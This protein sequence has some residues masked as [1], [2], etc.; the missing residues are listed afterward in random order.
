MP[1]RL[2][3]HAPVL[4]NTI[5]HCAGAIAFGILLYLLLIDWRR[6]SGERSTLPAIAAGLA[7][8]WNLGS[9]IGLATS[10]GDAVADAIIAASFSVLSLLPAVLLHISLRS[11]RRIL[12]MSG[13]VVS[14][15]AVLLHVGDLVTG[16]PRFHYAAILLVTFGFGALTAVSVGIESLAGKHDGSGARLA[17]AMV[18]FLFA[19]SFAHFESPHEAKRWSGEAALHHA[20]IPLALFVL[21]QDYRFL[22]LDAFIRFLVN[23]VLAATT[24][25]AAFQADE[26]F[27]LL[28][29][30]RQ[31]P[32]YAGIVFTMAC[33]ALGFFAYARTR[34]Q[35]FLT[36]T[37]F[38]R[39]N[40]DQPISKLRDM[41]S[42]PDEPD[43]LAGAAGIIAEFFSA[44]RFEIVAHDEPA[45]T[46]PDG[47][48]AVLDPSR[49]GVASWVQALAPLRFSRGD[50]HLLL[51]G[52]RTGGRRYL[53]ED[54]ELLERLSAIAAEQVERIRNAEMQALLTEAE[55]RALQAQIN[56]HF[57]FNSLNT[58]YGSIARENQRA[59][60]L[61]SNLAGLFRYSFAANRGLIRIE[62]ELTIVRAYLDIEQ[63]RLGHRLAVELDID[64]SVLPFEIP[65]LSIQP[66]VE[67]AI[68]HGVAAQTQSGFVRVEMKRREDTITVEISNSGRFGASN[69]GP[70]E[71]NGVGLAN[72]RRRLELCYGNES[73]LDVT[74]DAVSTTVRFSLPARSLAVAVHS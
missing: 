18:L 8:L 72:V 10:A 47:A 17:G 56:P 37:V 9:L 34:A 58:L 45:H 52:S 19:I 36:R 43:Y 50:T 1:D 51:L 3:I 74:S 14:T 12:W 33:L 49:W 40:A 31:D 61:V 35:R 42:S 41:A 67:N 59:R 21:L 48:I 13:Y 38:L 16:A 24:V 32:F 55:L 7:L 20:G 2:S 60:Q 22:L 15:L 4:V 23:G 62:E 71:G 28:A 5:G 63:L 66:L 68:K 46:V 54:I 11:G 69:Y 25:W 53:S 57:L 65:V 6:D 30:A 27:A 73:R 44:L 29:N 70:A 39:A 26:K 64:D